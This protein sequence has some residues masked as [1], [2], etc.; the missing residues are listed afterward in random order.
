MVPG[1]ISN[2][3]AQN[4]MNNAADINARS[5]GQRGSA[6]VSSQSS[7]RDTNKNL[8]DWAAKGDYAN[9]IAGINAKVQDAQLIQPSVSGQYAGE[10]FNLVNDTMELS[11]RWKMIDPAAIRVLGE[12][13]LRYGYAVRQFKTIPVSLQVMTKFTYWKLA[14]TYISSATVPES[15]KQAIRG[16]FEKGVTVWG[17][18]NDIGN[19]DIANNEPISGVTL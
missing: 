5:A 4:Q 15:F 19:I 14:E 3:I 12:Y 17:N 1:L 13:W 16:I 10:T 18:A 6:S 9:T 7:I 8:A 11:L 2:T